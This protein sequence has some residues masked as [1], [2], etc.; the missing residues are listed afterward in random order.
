MENHTRS[1]LYQIKTPELQVFVFFFK[2]NI[3]E[4][5][6]YKTLIISVYNPL[7]PKRSAFRFV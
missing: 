6:C 5:I 3:T 1:G 2:I 4:R 7:Y